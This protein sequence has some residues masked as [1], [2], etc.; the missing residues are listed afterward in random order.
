MSVHVRRLAVI[1]APSLI[2]PAIA[3][4]INE[5]P[6]RTRVLAVPAEVGASRLSSAGFSAIVWCPRPLGTLA[7]SR[8]LAELTGQGLPLLCLDVWGNAVLR[9]LARRAGAAF[10]PATADAPQCAWLLDRLLAD[11]PAQ[12]PAAGPGDVMVM[13][14]EAGVVARARAAGQEGWAALAEC[15][16]RVGGVTPGYAKDPASPVP[17]A[18]APL[19]PAAPPVPAGSL[20]ADGAQG[21]GV[22]GIAAQCFYVTAAGALRDADSAGGAG[23]TRGAGG[24]NVARVAGISGLVPGA[25]I[26]AGLGVTGGLAVSAELGA[27]GG[28]PVPAGSEAPDELVAPSGPGVPG[29]LMAPAGSEV[30]GGL[31]LPAG[32]GASGGLPVPAGLAASA[33]LTG[34]SDEFPALSPREEDFLRLYGAG[35]LLKS[36]A[37][38]MGLSINTV[39]TYRLRIREKY[40]RAGVVLQQR[41]EF[42]RA[43]RLRF[44]GFDGEDQLARY[45]KR[46]RRAAGGRGG[47]PC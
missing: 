22:P 35:V 38:E 28:L 42:H 16:S 21:S 30:P 9:S 31:V 5:L 33:G 23:A 13:A 1:D 20:G 36:I 26:P 46:S 6:M 4:M 15:V 24:P 41:L 27:S 8:R 17:A 3:A 19:V 37:Y 18:S 44:P 2:A 47:D 12:G 39:K 29:G 32:P 14:A 34:A 10:L 43:A 45:R 25:G 40:E 11:V 7:A